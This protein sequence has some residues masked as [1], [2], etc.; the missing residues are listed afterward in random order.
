[1]IAAMESFLAHDGKAKSIS[2]SLKQYLDIIGP[3]VP[4]GSLAL[5]PWFF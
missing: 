3:W 4:A 5:T 1:M 2:E